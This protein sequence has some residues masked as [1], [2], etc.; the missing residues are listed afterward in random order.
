MYIISLNAK[1]I[2]DV[3]Y[4]F[5]FSKNMSQRHWYIVE[6][7]TLLF[8]ALHNNRANTVGIFFTNNG[9]M[10]GTVELRQ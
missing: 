10:N 8:E 2:A 5:T 7:S 3:I 6:M 4:Y 1:L 9:I